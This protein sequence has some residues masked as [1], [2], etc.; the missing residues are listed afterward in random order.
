M[1][2]TITLKENGFVNIEDFRGFL[3]VDKVK[4]YKL[5]HNEDGT[6]IIRFY[7]KK[8]RLVKPYGKRK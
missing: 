5:K 3:D 2:Y 8:R 4:F 7:D 6:I 1:A